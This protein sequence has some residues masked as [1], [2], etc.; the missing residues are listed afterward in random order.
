[1]IAITKYFMKISGIMGG[2]QCHMEI[3]KAVIE[4]MHLPEMTVKC[5]KHFSLTSKHYSLTICRF[6]SPMKVHFHNII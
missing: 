2:A 3:M 1:M 6:I 4:K 5:V